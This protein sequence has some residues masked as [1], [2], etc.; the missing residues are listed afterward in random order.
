MIKDVYFDVWQVCSY[1]KKEKI[2]V[3]VQYVLQSI[4]IRNNMIIC[5][6]KSWTPSLD[7]DNSNYAI[8]FKCMKKLLLIILTL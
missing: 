7:N 6:M 1:K 8:E 4:L 2:I 3:V 5:G